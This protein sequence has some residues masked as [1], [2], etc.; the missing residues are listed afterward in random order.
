VDAIIVINMVHRKDR[1]QAIGERMRTMKV[2]GAKLFCLRG[3]WRPELP[4][5]GKAQSHA[6]AIRMAMERGWRRVMICQDDAVFAQNS[7]SWRELGVWS[8]SHEWDV[9]NLGHIVNADTVELV[10]KLD[11]GTIYQTSDVIGTTCYMVAAHYYPTLLDNYLTGIEFYDSTQLL[12]YVID[13]H[14]STLQMK[15]KWYIYEPRLVRQENGYTDIRRSIYDYGQLYRRPLRI[16]DT[17]REIQADAEES[18]GE[19]V[20]GTAAI[21]NDDKTDD[22]QHDTNHDVE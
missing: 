5:L 10:D 13:E 16:L 19:V 14:W 17:T 1:L 18:V 4:K 6:K 15:D 12:E 22:H 3:I 9:I 11:R 8:L 7:E 2:P 21:V 20:L